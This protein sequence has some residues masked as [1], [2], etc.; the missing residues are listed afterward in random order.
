MKNWLQNEYVVV[1]GASSGIGRALCKALILRCGAR[2]IGIGRKEEK[3]QTLREELGSY[4]DQF[5]YS[6]FDVAEKAAWQHFADGLKG[7]GIAPILLVHNAGI[8]PAFQT[9]RHADSATF[10]RVMQVNY[11]SVVY[12]TEALLPIL[13]RDGKTLPAIVNIS[14]SAALCPVVGTA[15]YSAS[16]AAIKGYT[17]ALQM[18]EKGR[19]HVGIVFPGTTATDLFADDPNTKNSALDYV[20]M[21]AEKMAKKILKKILARKRRA[22]LGWD[23]KC[24]NLVAKI[25]PVR[26]LFLIRGV[27][28]ISHSKVFCEVF[29]EEWG[30]KRR[31]S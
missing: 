14:S 11:F 12:G 26:G 23:A 2:V 19:T 25:A 6:L 15:A 31:K 18:E 16:K 5:T 20:A 30:E 8:F 3:M 7:A 21:P 17:E 9:V 10:E 28:K 4:A 13:K 22:T 27:M 24:M 29:K 1:S